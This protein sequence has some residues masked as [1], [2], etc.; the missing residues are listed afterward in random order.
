MFFALVF[1]FQSGAMFFE[2]LF[3]L[4]LTKTLMFLSFLA[5]LWGEDSVWCG[6]PVILRGVWIPNVG[7]PS[8][9][10]MGMVTPSFPNTPTGRAFLRP[11]V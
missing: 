5:F 8:S 7:N 2:T 4:V 6:D 10:G 3:F 1:G 9:P 11:P